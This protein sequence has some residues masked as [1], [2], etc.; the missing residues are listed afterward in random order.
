MLNDNNEGRGRARG[1]EHSFQL[2]DNGD[3]QGVQ[4]VLLGIDTLP[5][6][7]LPLPFPLPPFASVPNQS[8][9]LNDVIEKNNEKYTANIP[10][11]SFIGKHITHSHTNTYLPSPSS[12]IFCLFFRTVL[13]PS[14]H[15]S[16]LSLFISV[17]LVSD[18]SPSLQLLYSLLPSP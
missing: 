14:I 7:S 6:P 18:R 2:R 17:L 3:G 15:F 10:L 12:L 16:F 1:G 9:C 13:L 4:W 11:P 8:N 5:P